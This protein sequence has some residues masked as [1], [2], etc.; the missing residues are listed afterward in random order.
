LVVGVDGITTRSM[1]LNTAQQFAVFLK[2]L[3]ANNFQIDSG[4]FGGVSQSTVSRIVTRFSD[5]FAQE[6]DR[7][8]QWHDDNSAIAMQHRVFEEF[9]LPRVIGAID[10]THVKIVGPRENEYVFV[11][12]LNVACIVDD[13]YRFM[14]FSA[15][16]P[17]STHDSRAFR[18][19]ELHRKFANG[20][21]QGRL[22]G[23]SAYRAETYLLKP[24]VGRN[25]TESQQRYNDAIGSFRVC[26]EQSFGHLKRQFSALESGLRYEPVRASKIVAAAICLRNAAIAMKEPDPEPDPDFEIP[27]QGV[28]DY[29][30]SDP[31]AATSGRGLTLMQS[32]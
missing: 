8:V 16:W 12:S 1:P 23:D 28:D 32:I 21:I 7:F 11:N 27:P 15:K 25:L 4:D 10:G 2:L 20:E 6:S 22:V 17:G 9:R 18:E 5:W 24:F 29:D 3:S 14:W 30:G 26:V 19:S 13:N 31:D